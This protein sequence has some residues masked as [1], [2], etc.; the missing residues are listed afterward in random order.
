MTLKCSSHRKEHIGAC[1]WCGVK[2]CQE[3]I[4]KKEGRKYY[5]FKC[6]STLG[7]Y[8]RER[9]PRRTTSAPISG[10]RY[11]LQDGYLVLEGDKI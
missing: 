9:M 7:R 4:S 8:S 6:H 10:R 2:M 1:N 3:C 5:C 11:Q